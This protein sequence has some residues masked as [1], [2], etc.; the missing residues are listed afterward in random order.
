MKVRSVCFAF[1]STVYLAA[2]GANSGSVFATTNHVNPLTVA[3]YQA[4]AAGDS[5]GAV[6]LYTKAIDAKSMAPEMLVNALLNRGLAFQQQQKHELALADYS[7]ALTLDAMAPELRATALYNRGLSQQKLKHLSAAIEDFTNALLIN[8]NLAHAYLSRGAALRDSGQL[9]FALSDFERALQNNHPDP[10]RVYLSQAETYELLRRPVEQ[11]KMLEAALAANPNL[12]S[13]QTKLAELNGVKLD[14]RDEILTAS[15]TPVGGSTVIQK[16]SL[17]KAVE[18]TAALVLGGQK[19]QYEKMKK[20]YTDR[21][22]PEAEVAIEA[23]AVE[24][25]K[26]V[27][28]ESVP[29]IPAPVR[30]NVMPYVKPVPPQVK[31]E[32]V[33]LKEVDTIIVSSTSRPV[34]AM[35]DWAVQLASAVSEDAAWTT[36]KNMQK[37]NKALADIKPVVVKADLGA[38]GI[39]YRV[40]MA[41]FEEQKAALSA[42]QKLKSKGVACYASK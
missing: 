4:L 41:G 15:T 36:W 17:P 40:R 29:E 39:F 10:A 25:P 32:I 23:P 21:I 19:P 7:S 37:R 12:E 24:E 28:L 31:A 2:L 26:K 22:L 20:L 42:C 3:A 30:K 6:D 27:V 18:P 16:A 38:K 8:A 33:E 5:A 11:K 13:A 9:L 35:G 14:T 1:V 34:K